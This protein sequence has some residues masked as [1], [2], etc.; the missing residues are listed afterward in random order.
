VAVSTK[1]GV[2]VEADGTDG[3]A[4]GVTFVTFGDSAL[5]ETDGSSDLNGSA[6]LT[7]SAGVP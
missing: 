4:I 2:D 1:T 5:L 3:K 7:T 6:F